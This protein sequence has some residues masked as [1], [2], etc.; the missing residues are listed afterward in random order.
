MKQL[1]TTL[2]R[3]KGSQA[4]IFFKGLFLEQNWNLQFHTSLQ[5]IS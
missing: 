1:Q 3:E 5:L 4:C 2:K